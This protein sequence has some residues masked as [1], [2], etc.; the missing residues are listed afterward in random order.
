MQERQSMSSMSNKSVC[1]DS[2]IT[3]AIKLLLI[4]S[5]FAKRQRLL[6]RRNQFKA[7]TPAHSK[8]IMHQV[9]VQHI[10]LMQKNIFHVLHKKTS[11]QKAV[12]DFVRIVNEI[13]WK[14]PN[15]VL[16]KSKKKIIVQSSALTRS[17]SEEWP[18]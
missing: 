11:K 7:N 6:S 4:L 3:F 5:K 15:D 9:N 8:Q 10:N 2:F 14:M 12:S 1:S 17:F 18:N 16:F 13:N